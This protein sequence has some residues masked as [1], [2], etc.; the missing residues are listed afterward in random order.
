MSNKLLELMTKDQKVLKKIIKT[1]NRVDAL[2][3]AQESISDYTEKDFKK[4][5]KELEKIMRGDDR[6]DKDQ[7]DSVK[8]GIS[9]VQQLGILGEKHGVDLGELLKSWQ[10]Q[11]E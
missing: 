9:S 7:L 3:I 1:K 8:G 2:A 4:D 6:L 10:Q 11:L 5:I